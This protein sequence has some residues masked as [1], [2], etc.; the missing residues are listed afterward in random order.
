MDNKTALITGAGRGIGKAICLRLAE[1]GFGTII[2]ASRTEKELKETADEIEK[3]GTT[4]F[5]Y[6]IDISV[7]DQVIKL[8]EFLKTKSGTLDLLVNN[9]GIGVFKPLTET[10]AE[11]WNRVL[12]VNLNGTFLCAREAMKMMKT[13]SN[14]TIVNISSVVGIKGYP[15]QGAYTA[16]KHGMVGLTKVIAEEGREFG[17]RAHVIC[18]GGVNTGLVGDARP[19]INKEELLQPEDIAEL[20]VYLVN[21]PK[22]AMIDIVHIRRFTSKSF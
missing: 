19:D 13:Q 7:E 16:S 1:C 8:F 5:V 2:L 14:G 4:A 3:T 9:A 10:T 18:P 11:E 12:D 21:L 20:V 6:P 15:N 22:Q 17:I